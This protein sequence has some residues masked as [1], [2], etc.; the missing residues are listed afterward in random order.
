MAK[1]HKVYSES[2]KD[3]ACKLVTEQGYRPKRAAESLGI[4]ANTLLY[5]LRLRGVAAQPRKQEGTP[6]RGGAAAPLDKAV[7]EAQV[8]ELQDKVRRLEMEK[9]ILKKAT[10]FFAKDQL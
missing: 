7:L 6:P 1:V 8:K 5:W 3:A 4:H 2:Y 10:A 9:E